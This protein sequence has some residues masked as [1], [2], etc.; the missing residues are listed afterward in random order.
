M[1]HNLLKP[2]PIN[3]TEKVRMLLDYKYRV[4]TPVSYSL[5]PSCSITDIQNIDIEP[6]TQPRVNHRVPQV[7][8]PM[9]MAGASPDQ[10]SISHGTRTRW[11]RHKLFC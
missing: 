3:T 1:A 10:M 9:L 5:V 2:N 11:A 4:L 8:T 6:G 7:Q